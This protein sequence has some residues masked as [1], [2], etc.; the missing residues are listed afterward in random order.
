MWCIDI[1]ILIVFLIFGVLAFISTNKKEITFY[2]LEGLLFVTFCLS[3]TVFVGKPTITTT[4]NLERN[5]IYRY[6]ISDITIEASPNIIIDE[7]KKDY[8][9]TKLRDT[10]LYRILESRIRIPL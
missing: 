5:R 4:T 1:I 7:I 6:I 9:Y 2:V 8:P 10:K 3:L